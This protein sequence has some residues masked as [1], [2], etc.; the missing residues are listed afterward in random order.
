MII[1]CMLM[2]KN[3]DNNLCENV[4]VIFMTA[5]DKSQRLYTV[6]AFFLSVWINTPSQL[7]WVLES[8]VSMAD[9]RHS[10]GAAPCGDG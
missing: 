5:R 3:H 7:R 4:V 1:A 6:A 10:A 8:M 2:V 9:R